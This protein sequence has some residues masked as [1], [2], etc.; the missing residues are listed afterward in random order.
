MN[1]LDRILNSNTTL[2]GYDTQNE[3]S[4]KKLLGFLP[5]VTLFEEVEATQ[6][7]EHFTSLSHFRDYKLDSLLNGKPVNFVIIDL[8]TI[9]FGSEEM[10]IKEVFNEAAHLRKFIKE[11]QSLFYTL[12]NSDSSVKFKLILLS[13]LYV[14]M[15]QLQP[16]SIHFVAS[17]TALH[18]S[19]LVLKF[20]RDMVTIEK[21]RIS[22]DTY[23][24]NIKKELR[25]ITIDSLFD[26]ITTTT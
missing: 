8:S 22:T 20:S 19:D 5:S 15:T 24:S 25:E 18:I 26:E 14:I 10:N 2:I 21:D 6:V 3:T 7:F 13:K 4:V 12:S 16:P 11:L 23:V 17:D 1:I 9:S